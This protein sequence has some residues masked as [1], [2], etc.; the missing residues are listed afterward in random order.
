MIRFWVDPVT[1]NPPMSTLSP[2]LDA[3][4]GGDVGEAVRRR[5][6]LRLGRRRRRWRERNIVVN[7][8]EDRT[9][10]SASV[11]PPAGFVNVRLIVSSAS[12]RCVVDDR[13]REC[14]RALAGGEVEGALRGVV[15]G[16]LH[17]ASVARPYCARDQSSA[18]SDAF[19]GDDCVRLLAGRV[20]CAHEPERSRTGNR[21]R[22]REL[23]SV[24]CQRDPAHSSCRRA[25]KLPGHGGEGSAKAHVAGVVGRRQQT[26]PRYR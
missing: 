25:D 2:L 11:A 15:V 9:S 1:M 3:Q 5:T 8:G 7:Y 23:R 22:G 18:A 24:P 20:G 17:R 4:A 26:V 6:A 16:A 10:G 21:H 13:H 14:G 19:H 12:S